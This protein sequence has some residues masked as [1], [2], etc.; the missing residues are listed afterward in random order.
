MEDTSLVFLFELR[1][2]RVEKTFLLLLIIF[3]LSGCASRPHEVKFNT[4]FDQSIDSITV[5]NGELINL[6]TI[7]REGHQF[8]GW[9]VSEYPDSALYIESTPVTKSFTLYAKW[10]INS[11]NITYDTQGGTEVT[12]ITALFGAS[13][14]PPSQPLMNGYEFV[15][16]SLNQN[17]TQIY[18]FRTM[19][20]QDLLLYAIWK[21]VAK[22]GASP[23]E[24][25]YVTLDTMYEVFLDIEQFVVFRYQPTNSGSYTMESFGSFDTYVKVFQLVEI[26]DNSIT[27]EDLFQ[28]NQEDDFGEGGNFKLTIDMSQS[29]VYFIL[30]EMFFN[31]I[32]SG[33]IQ[34]KLIFSS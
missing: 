11:Y 12:S 16:W 15:G 26:D 10:R 5:L 24:A 23:N 9:A 21:E 29:I 8:L 18:E 4:G 28:I 27:W 14:Y 22:T 6:P 17:S 33:T 31:T 1:R 3:I 32:D 25:I 7:S 34:F 13:I 2:I 30:V 20:G 19:P